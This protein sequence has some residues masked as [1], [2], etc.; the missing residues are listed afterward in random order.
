[1]ATAEG[2]EKLRSRADKS[3]HYFQRQIQRVFWAYLSA[4]ECVV[5]CCTSILSNM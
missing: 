5:D 3:R 2:T 4:L 1:M